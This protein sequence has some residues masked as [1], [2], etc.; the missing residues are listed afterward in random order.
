M[1]Y[2]YQL[3][4]SYPPWS[5]CLTLIKRVLA[6]GKQKYLP[7]F[8]LQS[9]RLLYLVIISV[10]SN[11]L[12]ALLFFVR[13]LRFYRF[14][15]SPSS[16]LNTLFSETDV[17]ANLYTQISLTFWSIQRY[18]A[19][20]VPVEDFPFQVTSYQ[21]TITLHLSILQSIWHLTTHSFNLSA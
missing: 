16:S 18:F 11:N 2:L 3:S 14:L 6:K 9:F 12:N 20:V 8:T 1:D 5:T 7:R 4:V 17:W 21:V 10:M 13:Y 19:Y 15:I